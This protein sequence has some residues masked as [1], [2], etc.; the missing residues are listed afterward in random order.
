M[1]ELTQLVNALRRPRLLLQAV[2]HGLADYQR[3]RVLRRVLGGTSLPTPRR[4]V[5]SLLLAEEVL[6]AARTARDASYSVARHVE[7]LIA[8]VAEARSLSSEAARAE[9]DAV[10]DRPLRRVRAG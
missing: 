10:Q 3:E 2:R 9:R 4:A 7:V 5:A 8:L 6:E 1:T